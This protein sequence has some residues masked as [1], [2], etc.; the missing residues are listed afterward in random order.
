MSKVVAPLQSFSASGKIGKSLVFF[1]HLGRN[2]VRGLVTPSNPKSETQGDSRLLLGAL[3]RSVSGVVHPSNYYN[4][5]IQAV[6]SGQTWVSYFIRNIIN[7]FG[8]GTTGVA[9]LNAELTAHEA[10]N[11]EAQAVNRGLT[12][13]TISYALAAEN[14]ITAGAQLYALAKHAFSVKASNPSLF[15]DTVFDTALASWTSSEVVSFVTILDSVA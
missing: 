5:V 1:S 15:D 6:P 3:G 13:L 11:W 12:D 10:T 2:V 7:V 14:T 4:D 8:T 9:A